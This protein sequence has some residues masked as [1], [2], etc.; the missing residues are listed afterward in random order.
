MRAGRN[1]ERQDFALENNVVVAGWN[2]APDLRPFE[3]KDAVKLSLAE[4]SPDAKP[5]RLSNWAGQ[6]WAF[7][8]RIQVGDLV[9][10]PLKGVDAIAAGTV[11]GPYRFDAD[12]PSGARH[13]LPVKWLSKDLPRGRFDQDLLFSLGAFLTVCQITRNDAENRI[14]AVV[15]GKAVASYARPQDLE[16][17]DAPE[18]GIPHD[19]EGWAREQI[20]SLI[21]RK[22]AGH[23]LSQLVADILRAEGY[24]LH[25]SPPGPDGGVDI[26][27][28][29]GPFGFEAPKLCV[30]VKSGDGQQD[31]KVVRELKGSMND[32]GAELG[33]FVAWGGFKESVKKELR[34]DFFSMRLWDAGDLVD[35][36]LIHYERLSDETKADLPLKR[37]W[38]PVPDSD[39]D[40]AGA[41]AEGSEE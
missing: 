20:R 9:L 25:L 35:R 15:A 36:V 6:L 38:A 1:G 3:S 28:G 8:K 16:P 30:Q 32:V 26:V 14:R 17:T 34:R 22:F 5:N 10:L 11:S 27:A 39:E 19:I 4:A 21:S 31:V 12:A 33:L 2:E 18:S 41:L 7:A 13:Q 37:I 24:Q 29:K 23:A 40:S